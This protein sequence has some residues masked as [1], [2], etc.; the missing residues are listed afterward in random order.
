V[1]LDTPGTTKFLLSGFASA[2]FASKRHTDSSFSANFA[3][4][5]LWKLND[6][7]LLESE[8]DLTLV[9]S[10]TDLD[11]ERAQIY[12]LI[13]DYITLGAGKFLSPMNFL[14]DRLHQV[15]KLPDK[16]LAIQ[17][18][19]PE[20]NLGLQLRGGVPVG[21]RRLGYAVYVANAPMIE[22]ENRT[23]LGV[24][25]FEN[26]NNVGGHVAVGGRVGFYPIPEL[27]IGYGF[28]G[29]GL[30]SSGQDVDGW[31]HSL[32]ANYVRDVTWLKGTLN[33]LAQWA[34]SDLD[35]I[36][37]DPAGGLGFGPVTF[38]ND[39][40]GGYVQIAY[41]PTMASNRFI[42]RLES[43]A[44]YERFD[45][46]RS[47]AGFDEQRWTLG[48]NYWLMPNAVVKTAYQFDERS[49][50]LEQDAFLVQFKVG[51]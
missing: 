6:R 28:Q 42:N 13:N 32:D 14:E 31:L 5:F 23:S 16:P 27:E 11:L 46:Q 10:D 12:Y 21:E 44:R 2:G 3:P 4:L 18:L 29:S 8:L 51:F 9:A 35:P 19:L 41:R 24:L 37:F 20:T 43:I 33:L 25:R 45:Q 40:S 22:T 15:S 7:L 39:R 48:L 17:R 49:D 30:G 36:T 47:A 26:Y 38:S 34:W 50:D 1:S